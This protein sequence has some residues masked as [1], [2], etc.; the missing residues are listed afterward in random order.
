MTDNFKKNIIYF[1]VGF[2]VLLM[3]SNVI[4]NLI[5]VE[6]KKEVQ[7][8]M[9]AEA[10]EKKF[11]NCLNSFGIEESWQ[12]VKII[13]N[14]NFDS[15]KKVYHIQIPTDLNIP[16]F[17]KELEYELKNEPVEIISE[18]RKDN[19]ISAVKIHSNDFLKFQAYLNYDKDISRE[20]FKFAFLVDDFYNLSISDMDDL[21]EIQLMFAVSIIPSE[22]NFELLKSV[23]K[24]KKEN[25]LIINDEVS[26]S[27]YELETSTSK[28][29]LKSSII[30]IVTDFNNSIFFMIDKASELY[31]S[32]AYNFI[33]DELL[34][35]KIRLHSYENFIDLRN[36]ETNDL[37]SLFKFYCEDN[38]K[39]KNI[40]LIDF[41]GIK[42]LKEEIKLYQKKGNKLVNPSELIFNE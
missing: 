12:N 30:S 6:K 40:F 39:N 42:T 17:L 33:R 26:D 25:Y 35:R 34:K 7:N 3:I 10:I 38:S 13:N 29:R 15:L 11:Q 14:K 41:N 24:F 36:K 23:N 37:L 9:T 28:T 4:I 20:K 8:E 21:L 1:F 19:G 31:S 22:V 32:T 18:E 2:S 16:Q 5:M 27:K